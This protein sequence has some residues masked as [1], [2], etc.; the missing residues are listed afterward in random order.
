MQD[1][2]FGDSAV[3]IGHVGGPVLAG[4]DRLVIVKVLDR[5]KSELKPL[6]EVHDGI[7]A[8]LRKEAGTKAAYNAAEGAQAKLDGGASFDDVAK[9]LGVT[10]EPAKFISRTEASV[11]AQILTAAF[12][13]PK[14][15]SGPTG[16]P[17]YR[18]IRLTS[19][20]AAIMALTGLKSQPTNTNKQ[21]DD[22]FA[23]QAAAR[24]GD[25][26]V[27]A[28]VDELRRTADVKKNLKAF[29]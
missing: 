8:A 24:H 17:V 10:A 18:A 6:S 9:E 15:V 25:E 4:E 27:A 13:A 2:V 14:P 20:G 29:E 26:D 1:L 16:K 7:V 12:G 28:Y 21:A 22:A 3:G 11:P 23:K 19:G 5:K